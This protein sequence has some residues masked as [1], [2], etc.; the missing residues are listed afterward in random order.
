MK[1]LFFNSSVL[2][3]LMCFCTSV[4]AVNTV[5]K[6]VKKT[7]FEFL[8]EVQDLS[9]D[10]VLTMTA[11]S[12][13]AETGRTL[14]FGEKI[15]L[16]TAKKVLNNTNTA[17]LTKGNGK[18]TMGLVSTILGGVGLLLF[19]IPFFPLLLSIVGL[20]LGFL[21]LKRDSSRSLSIVGII[22]S[23]IVFLLCA[24]ILIGLAGAS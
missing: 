8:N 4:F 20:I 23:G 2:V 16:W 21:G 11:K 5:E 18:N 1:K 14:K 24:V 7:G 9:V 17:N 13:A 12:F 10:K 3:L 15:K 19:W 22:L 6:D